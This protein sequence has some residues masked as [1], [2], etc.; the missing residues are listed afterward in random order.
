MIDSLP[1]PRP[2]GGATVAVN[3]GRNIGWAGQS[4]I[5]V[6]RDGDSSA[7]TTF[8]DG[9]P[10]IGWWRASVS[11]MAFDD[12]VAR[13]H[14]SGYERLASS[15]TLPPGTMVVTLG[16]RLENEKA[17]ILYP[18]VRMPPALAPVVA[19]LELIAKEV[20]SHP[21]RVLR[22]SAEWGGVAR[23]GEAAVVVTLANAGTEPFPMSNPLHD[24]DHPRG[25]GQGWN[26]LRLVLKMDGG[27]D[28]K[29]YDLTAADVRPPPGAVRTETLLMKP[30]ESLRF[31][32]HKKAGLRAGRRYQSR[33]EYASVATR[34]DD[35]SLVQGVLWM[36]PGPLSVPAGP[37]WK[38]W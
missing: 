4:E 19:S 38:G 35:P 22:G 8:N 6:Q 27:G 20:R 16:E 2:A 18:F 30:G 23:D 34:A 13:L 28:E 9:T 36:D 17:P 29:Q 26:G 1:H 15:A 31:E 11:R 32:V 12:L 24:F 7:L 5:E 25:K 14:A 21:L 37:W 33:V 10:E 3:Y